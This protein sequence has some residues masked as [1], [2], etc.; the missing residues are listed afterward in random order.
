[1]VV[2]TERVKEGGDNVGFSGQE[3]DMYL[4]RSK[5]VNLIRKK[6]LNPGDLNKG[7]MGKKE[8]IVN[9]EG[10]VMMLEDESV[11][12]KVLVWNVREAASK[13]MAAVI[14]DMKRR[15]KLDIVVIL[16]PR[17]IDG[18]KVDI[19]LRYEQFLHC[20]VGLDREELL[21]TAIYAHLNEHK[22]NRIWDILQNLSLEI[23]ELW[24]L[25]RDFNEIKTPLE[26]KGGGRVKDMRCHKFN[27]W[28]QRCNLLDIEAKRPFF[29]WKGPKWEGLE[30]VYKRLDRCLCNIQWQ[31]QF[32]N[33]EVHIL[34]RLCSD[35]HPICVQLSEEVRSFRVQ[36]FQFQIAWQMHDCFEE[37]MNNSWKGRDEAHVK[38]AGLQQT[39]TDWNKEVFGN[40]QGAYHEDLTGEAAALH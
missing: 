12:M 30:R 19:I 32:P 26:Q 3:C 18:L 29:T 10:N 38:L 11:M 4:P 13:G 24:L 34:P 27:D 8:V 9:R 16:E 14:R 23:E 6:N 28:I 40:I 37:M 1:M 2:D 25:A 7:R 39:L 36:P 31:E 22:R 15:Y 17:I 20:K 21:F 5:I 33:V 35:H